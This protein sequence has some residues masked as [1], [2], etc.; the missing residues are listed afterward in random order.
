[1]KIQQEDVLAGTFSS[2]R[3]N[4]QEALLLIEQLAR[5]ANAQKTEN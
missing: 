2:I 3:V 1:M 4:Y 5:F